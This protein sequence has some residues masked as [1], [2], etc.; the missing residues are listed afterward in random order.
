MTYILHAYV[1]KATDAKTDAECFCYQGPPGR[2]G[3]RGIQ[4]PKGE[5]GELIIPPERRGPKG[6]KGDPGYSGRRGLPG[7]EGP[8][9]PRG[10]P[11]P[12]GLPGLKVRLRAH[13]YFRLQLFM[14][15][16]LDGIVKALCFPVHP[17]V[18]SCVC[19]LSGQILLLQYLMNGLNNFD[20]IDKE[21][22]LAFTDDLVRF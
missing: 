2:D 15:S 14:P 1:V 11:G 21:Y 8:P 6:V 5:E 18:R 12:T 20:K 13:V 9:G 4:G 10:P 7:Q 17:A 3:S 19:P 22:L 16:L